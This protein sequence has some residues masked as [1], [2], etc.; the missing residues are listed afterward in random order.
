MG[1]RRGRLGEQVRAARGRR[2]HAAPPGCSARSSSQDPPQVGR[3][4][5]GSSRSWRQVTRADR[6]PRRGG[7]D[8]AAG[9]SRTPVRSRGRRG[10]RARRSSRCSAT[11]SRAREPPANRQRRVEPRP[12]QPVGVEEGDEPLLEVVARDSTR[13]PWPPAPPAALAAP[14][15]PGYRSSRWGT[16]EPVGQPPH[17]RLVQ[18]PARAAARRAPRR[19]RTASATTEVTGIP[20]HHPDL[21]RQAGRARCARIPGRALNSRGRVTS[22]YDRRAR[23][24][25]PQLPRRA[26]AQHR[27]RSAGAAPPP[28]TAPRRVSAR[29]PTA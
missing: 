17:L 27:P 14:R 22:G 25:P 24:D 26:V 7:S 8:R 15:R 5:P 19:G 23:H 21:V 28:S 12:R 16:R 4:R 10:R 11:G 13:A 20:S 3:D 1:H 18:R 2:G 9:R 29:W 6:H